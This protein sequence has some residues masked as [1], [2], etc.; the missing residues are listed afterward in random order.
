MRATTDA[1][2]DGSVTAQIE[3]LA[4]PD[5]VD[6]LGM[7]VGRIHRLIEEHRLPATRRNGTLQV[8]ALAIQDDEPLADLRGTLLVLH[9]AGFTD[10]E[11]IDWLH[12]IEPSIGRAP[13][14][15][16][17]AGRKHEVRRVAQALG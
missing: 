1:C 16:L 10:D 8:P 13:I 3:W 7:P 2:H 6:V 15:A 9:D 12:E 17:R 11:V 14:E 4:V 5:L